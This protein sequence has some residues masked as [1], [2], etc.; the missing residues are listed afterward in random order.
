MSP[1]PSLIRRLETGL[2]PLSGLLAGASPE[3]LRQRPPSGKWSAHENLAHLAHF[4][5]VTLGRL[6]RILTEE[7]PRLE[8]LRSD[9]DP[10]FLELSARSTEA[11]VTELQKLRTDLLNRVRG[12]GDAEL[13]RVGV[14]GAAGP[15]PLS[16]WLEL[17]AVHEAHHLYL[18]FWAVRQVMNA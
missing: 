7:S 8:R 1:S 9:E 3:Q 13:A 14:H 4:T 17:Y 10:V 15:M 18:A 16:Q 12:L 11:V 2:E 6:E 5:A